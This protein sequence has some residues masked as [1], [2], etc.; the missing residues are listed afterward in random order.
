MENISNS[1]SFD[2]NF[3]PTTTDDELFNLIKTKS[4]FD[5]N[6]ASTN[7]RL[8]HDDNLL[9]QTSP[10]R[11]PSMFHTIIETESISDIKYGLT[12]LRQQIQDDNLLKQMWHE[13]VPSIIEKQ[14]ERLLTILIYENLIDLKAVNKENPDLIQLAAAANNLA[15]LRLLFENGASS[16]VLTNDKNTILHI[17][18]LKFN[19][20]KVEVVAY[21][22]SQA[23][24]DF[25][26]APNKQ[27]ETALHLA[28]LSNNEEIIETLIKFGANKSQPGFLGKTYF[29]YFDDKFLREDYKNGLWIR[30]LKSHNFGKY[31]DSAMSNEK[32]ISQEA[33]NLKKREN[34][35]E[36]KLRGYAKSDDNYTR[37]SPSTF[38]KKGVPITSFYN[39][40]L[41]IRAKKERVIDYWYDGRVE[42]LTDDYSFE[43]TTLD[44]KN[45]GQLYDI[46]EEKISDSLE[47]FFKSQSRKYLLR[48]RLESIS[49]NWNEGLFRYQR[50]DVI[51]LYIASAD[52]MKFVI[53]VAKKLELI[54]KPLY[55]YDW[56][57]GRLIEIIDDFKSLDDT[58]TKT[59]EKFLEEITRQHL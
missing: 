30:G 58:K 14:N 29:D 18:C 27:G 43:E 32:T 11:I 17:S 40:G 12:K 9:E 3:Y 5:A 53:E 1:I 36:H 35:Q 59:I 23:K 45:S 24:E 34:L 10:D 8:N 49:I 47:T 57:Y 25:I 55:Y 16:N 6:N 7:T 13:Q 20:P 41:L 26:N 56:K 31:P 50:M 42:V 19:N 52:T 21:L 4:I 2:L 48:D 39:S 28:L 46:G 15:I 51:G 44:N 22:C 37:Y 33:S 54:D 38:I